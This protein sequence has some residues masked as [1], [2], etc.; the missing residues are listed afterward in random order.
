MD[1]RS[2]EGIAVMEEGGVHQCIVLREFHQ[3]LQVTEVA[4]AASHTIPSTVLIQNKHLAWAE[5][6]L[7]IQKKYKLITQCIN[8]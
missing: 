6:S 4:M 8:F 1:M 2:A 5:P 7:H 3:V